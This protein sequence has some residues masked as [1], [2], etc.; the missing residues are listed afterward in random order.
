MNPFGKTFWTDLRCAL[1]AAGWSW[2]LIDDT[3]AH[4]PTQL[5]VRRLNGKAVRVL[6]DGA[7]RGPVVS[8]G[9]DD[10]GHAAL[11]VAAQIHQ[12]VGRRPVMMQSA[13]DMT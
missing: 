3:L 13:P 8:S 9:L 11:H 2:N 12:I 1:S 5:V 6:I 4:P 10:E 7:E